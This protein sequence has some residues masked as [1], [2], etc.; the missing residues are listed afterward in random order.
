MQRE[1]ALMPQLEAAV[2]ISKHVMMEANVPSMAQQ[3][4][5]YAPALELKVL[6]VHIAKYNWVIA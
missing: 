2:M 1:H 6:Q 4:L 3:T 5:H